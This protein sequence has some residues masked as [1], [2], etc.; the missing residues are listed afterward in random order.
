MLL[1]FLSDSGTIGLNRLLES[2]EC[3]IWDV[4]IMKSQQS[5]SQTN[6]ENQY[7]Q[8]QTSQQSSV[9]Q[10]QASQISSAATETSS[11]LS[12]S[13]PSVSDVNNN[14]SLPSSSDSS[15]SSSTSFDEIPNFS[16]A[17]VS[18]D[19]TEFE[20]LFSR[21]HSVREEIRRN[22]GDKMTDEERRRK[23]EDAIR[24]LIGQMG[25]DESED[26]QLE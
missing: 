20:A 6:N 14:S 11:A 4:A 24:A 13:T 15:S 18:D 3:N 26:E 23:A 1:V 10:Q 19:L 21:I 8:S 16:D 22:G 12:S 2:L 9:I 17:S 25:L 7:S 5:K